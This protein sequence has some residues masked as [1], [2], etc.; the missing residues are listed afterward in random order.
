MDFSA[1]QAMYGLTLTPQQSAAAQHGAGPALLLAV[2]GSGK[3]TVLVTRLGYLVLGRGVDPGELLTVTYTKAATDDL[4]RR[5]AALFG[6]E[7]AGRLEFRTINGLCARIIRR[8]EQETGRAAFSLLASEGETVRLL[9]EVWQAQTRQ[10]PTEADLKDLRTQITFAKNMLLGEAEMASLKLESGEAFLPLYR[11]YQEVLLRSRQMDYD[12]QMVYGL[13]IL[14]TCPPVLACFQRKYRYFCVDEAQDTSKIQHLILRRLA[15]GTGNLFLVGDE[16]QSIYGFRAA[17]PQ[18]LLEFDQVF[19]NARV[20]FLEENFRSTP[21]I[22]SAAGAFIRRNRAR[23]DKHMFTRNPDGPP[24][25][26]TVLQDGR[27]QYRYLLQIARDCREETAVLYRNHYSAVPLIDLLEREGIPYRCRAGEGSFF[28][29]FLV[30][31]ILDILRFAFR[32]TDGDAFWRFYYKLG[33]GLKKD[34]VAAVLRRQ[35]GQPDAP[36][37]SLL[38][39]APGLEPWVVGKV[40]ALKTHLTHLLQEESFLAVNRIVRYM[41]YG[42]YLKN[43]GA[44][45][46]RLGP[47]LAL[48]NQN[49]GLEQFLHRMEELEGVVARGSGGPGCPFVLSTIHASKGLEYD[50]VILIDVLDGIFPSVP[51]PRDG[52]RLSP[53]EESV[54]EEERRLFYV[55]VTRARQKLEILTYLKAYGQSAPPVSSFVSALLPARTPASGGGPGGPAGRAEDYRPGVRV[56]HRHFGPGT[57]LLRQGPLVL[58]ALD[59]GGQRKF[60]LQACLDKGLLSLQEPEAP[61]GA[62]MPSK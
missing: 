57:V 17:W 58:L 62:E 59:A 34:Q 13:R 9:R 39:E 40:K 23:R 36:V 25:R 27:N 52:Q 8:Y 44:D 20:L 4:R 7:L 19:P 2:P 31:D 47:L 48:A 24:I 15:S 56:A 41:G 55:A 11:R 32:P 49:P 51:E 16:D 18:A 61:A 26:H 5:C 54:L 10:F 29:H 53:E 3:T 33:C 37:L 12:D 46:G 45:T 35:A 21:A 30:R 50:R 43:R 42:D 28:G 22:V 6:E 14:R 38:L 60:D 1:F